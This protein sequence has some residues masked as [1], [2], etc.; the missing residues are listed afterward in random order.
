MLPKR[1]TLT[2]NTRP[3]GMF[4]EELLADVYQVWN[5][6]G[7]DVLEFS[8]ETDREALVEA[9][10]DADRLETFG[11]KESGDELKALITQHGYT[12]VLKELSKVVHL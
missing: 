6:I 7:H 10:I 11:S 9:C 1:N 2:R 8:D 3:V 12:T 4:T 5:S